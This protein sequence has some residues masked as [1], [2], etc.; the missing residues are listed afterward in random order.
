MKPESGALGSST[1]TSAS[2]ISFASETDTLT[3]L[4][5]CTEARKVEFC[6]TCTEK[7]SLPRRKRV[8]NRYFALIHIKKTSTRKGGLPLFPFARIGPLMKSPMLAAVCLKSCDSRTA[9][10]VDCIPNIPDVDAPPCGSFSLAAFSIF[11]YPSRIS[12]V[13]CSGVTCSRPPAPIASITSICGPK[14]SSTLATCAS[15]L[16]TMRFVLSIVLLSCKI[17]LTMSVSDDDPIIA[18]SSG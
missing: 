8:R 18:F 14:A 1:L 12:R 10:R 2:E 15:A 11:T 9:A 3:I 5:L 16:K 7:E 4:I 17:I 6:T 13:L